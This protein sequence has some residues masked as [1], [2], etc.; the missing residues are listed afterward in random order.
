[1][2]DIIFGAGGIA[3]FPTKYHGEV[4]L[5]EMKWGIICSQ[6][7]RRYYKHN[8]E[9]IPTTLINPDY[10]RHHK[11]NPHQVLYYKQFDRYRITET[12]EIPLRSGFCCVILDTSTARVCTVMPTR[13]LKKG[14]EFNL[15]RT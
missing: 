9:K 2:A 8:G 1:M 15:P 10:V 5:S 4:T 13:K 11:S 12:A 14:K 3:R 7:E 6:P